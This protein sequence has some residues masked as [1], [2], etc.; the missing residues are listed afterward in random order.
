MAKAKPNTDIW[1][2][3]HVRSLAPDAAS[4]P[5]AQKVLKKGGFG[6][7]EPT[8]D[9]RGWWVVCRGITDTYQVSVRREKGSDE[10]EC[11]CT[12]PSYKDPCKHAL[13][14]LMYLVDHP[15]LRT[16]AEEAKATTGD[17][18]GLLR[19]AFRDPDDDTPRLVFA[20]YL[21]ENDQPDRAALIRYQCEQARLKPNAARYKELTALVKPLVAKLKKHVE[22]LPE[23]MS[24]QF[25]RGFVTLDAH[26]NHFG[27]VGSLPARFTA[28]FRDGWIETLSMYVYYDVAQTG[29]V[30]LLEH[31]GTLDASR[32]PIPDEALLSLVAETVHAR[33][34]GRLARIKVH[35]DN[36]KLLDRLLSAH[37]GEAGVPERDLEPDRTHYGLNPRMF[38]LL[39][40]AGRLSGARELS[41]TCASGAPLGDAQVA[42]LLTA[43]LGRLRRLRLENWVLT[44]AGVEALANSPA[45]ARLTELDL[46]ACELGAGAAARLAAATGLRSVETLRVTERQLTD[47]GV[48]ALARSQSFPNLTTLDLRFNDDLTA[49]GVAAV[50]AAKHFPKLTVVSLRDLALYDAELLPLVLDA[51]DRPYLAVGFTAVDVRRWVDDGEVIVEL[52]DRGS[53]HEHLFDDLATCAGAKRVTQFSA[54]AVGVGAD[55]VAALAAGFDPARLWLLDLTDNPLHNP[56]AAALATTFANFKLQEL[57][58]RACRIQSAG[59]AA[60]VN[61]PLMATVRALD[62]S[63][64]NIGKAGVAALVKAAVPPALKELVLTDCRLTADDKKQ[65]KAKFGTKVK[66]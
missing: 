47:A 65:L 51:P 8:G 24:Y 32:Y 9:G 17:F 57:K 40:R 39:L 12:C 42:A 21:E 61:S 52:E 49:R 25:R 26:V 2:H 16:E 18:E 23:G 38:D 29:I 28:L 20:D 36:R 5:A 55:Q 6:T 31:V 53:Y 46:A 13:A 66:V 10:F 1:T 63:G 14:L 22:P 54:P 48:E 45:L 64:N 59:V 27:D 19:A 34:S 33:T 41:L 60:L 37:P 35:K 62:L 56:G 30:P 11:E 15:E 58:L 4:I 7:V 44:R 50:L 3:E 43:D